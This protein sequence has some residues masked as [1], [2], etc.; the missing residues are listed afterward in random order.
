MVNVLRRELW[1]LDSPWSLSITVLILLLSVELLNIR[2]SLEPW[3][4]TWT[5]SEKDT[6]SSLRVLD[7]TGLY[8]KQNVT[9]FICH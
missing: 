7:S 1:F 4:A 9:E 5:D 6:E 8:R 2:S 3:Q